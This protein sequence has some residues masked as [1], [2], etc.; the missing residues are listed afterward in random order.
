MYAMITGEKYMG[1]WQDDQRHGNGVIV[2][3][4]GMYF[5]GSFM[6]GKMTVSFSSDEKNWA[7]R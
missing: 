1:F 5:E 6:Q 4:L 3:L 2:T 7:F